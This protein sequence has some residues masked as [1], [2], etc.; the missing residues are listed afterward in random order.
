MKTLI[1]RVSY[2]W[3]ERTAALEERA[4]DL[5]VPPADQFMERL[6]AFYDTSRQHLQSASWLRGRERQP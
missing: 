4:V 6:A 5:V 1:D 3:G 2:W